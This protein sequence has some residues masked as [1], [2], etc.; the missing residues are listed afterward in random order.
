P[1]DLGLYDMG[2]NV[3]EWCRDVY[4]KKAYG[5]HS[6]ENPWHREKGSSRV[7]RGG[8]FADNTSALRCSNRNYAISA[9]KS[10][11][12]GFRLVLKR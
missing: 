10:E 1:N 4:D 12:I 9:M 8:S 5:A 6:L 11:Y 2:G 7:V 3:R